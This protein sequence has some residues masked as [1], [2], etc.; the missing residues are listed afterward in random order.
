MSSSPM[1]HRWLVPSMGAS[2]A[3]LLPAS[4][5]VA[6]PGSLGGA[7]EA[8]G[9]AWGGRPLHSGEPGRG[10]RLVIENGTLNSASSLT[11]LGGAASELYAA[12]PGC[13]TCCQTGDCSMA[14]G[15]SQPGTCCMASAA[16][17]CPIGYR[18]GQGPQGFGCISPNTGSGMVG[19]PAA[20]VGAGPGYGATITPLQAMLRWIHSHM[21]L[22]Y[23]MLGLLS[24]FVGGPLVNYISMCLCGIQMCDM[25]GG[26]G[27]QQIMYGP[28]Y[29]GGYPTDHIYALC[30]VPCRPPSGHLRA[31]RPH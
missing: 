27:A 11:L 10:T 20:I 8:G 19:P 5:A 15:S 2:V 30:R 22:C 14:Y 23:I 4:M 24:C 26:Q 1:R 9:G 31:P 12:S 16:T 17:C 13:Q 25:C 21:L 6:S 29:G 7:A 3:A 18:C 28:A